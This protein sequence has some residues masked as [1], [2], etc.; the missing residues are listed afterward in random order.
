MLVDDSLYTLLTAHTHI[1]IY[2]VQI[3]THDTYT[4]RHNTEAVASH[5]LLFLIVLHVH[6]EL[7]KGSVTYTHIPPSLYTIPSQ[8][9]EGIL[10]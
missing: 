4:H 8:S 5:Y 6:S 9:S 7:T 2:I 1:H 10:W 3:Y